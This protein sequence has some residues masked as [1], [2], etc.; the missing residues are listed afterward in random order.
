MAG[1]G[2]RPGRGGGAVLAQAG[3]GSG[4]AGAGEEGEVDRILEQLRRF[5]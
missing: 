5:L 3:R 4:D 1:S 2:G